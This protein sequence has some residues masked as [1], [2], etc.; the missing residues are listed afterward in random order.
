M[1]GV[2]PAIFS[3]GDPCL[4]G[5][6]VIVTWGG[7]RH[8]LCLHAGFLR[9]ACG[10]NHTVAQIKAIDGLV[11]SFRLGLKRDRI[12]GGFLYQRGVLLRHAIHLGHRQPDLFNTTALFI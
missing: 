1:A 9:T 8:T 11:Q 5:L 3:E 4:E 12:G 6:P 2:Y 7:Y 10:G